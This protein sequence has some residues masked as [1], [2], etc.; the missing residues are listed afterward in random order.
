MALQKEV[1]NAVRLLCNLSPVKSAFSLLQLLAKTPANEPRA[2]FS[3][4]FIKKSPWISSQ[5]LQASPEVR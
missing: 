2:Y 3:L 1:N 5:A 4:H